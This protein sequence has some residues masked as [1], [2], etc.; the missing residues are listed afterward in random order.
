MYLFINSIEVLAI[1]WYVDDIIII[2]VN[3]DLM[4]HVTILLS[5]D[6]EEIYNYLE[7]HITYNSPR[8]FIH[9]F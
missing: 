8:G 6:I 7:I 5:R 1:A 2:N 9:R 4:Q 3:L